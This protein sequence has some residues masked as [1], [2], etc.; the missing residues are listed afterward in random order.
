MVSIDWVTFLLK[1]ILVPIFIGVVSLAGRRWGTTVS[2]WLVG[3]PLSSAPVA[4]FL[5]L[6]QGNVFA[7]QAAEGILLGIVSVYAFCVAYSWPAMHLG[8]FRSLLAG[9]AAFFLSTFLL[10]AM[11]LPLI[12]EV[13]VSL[14]TL[15]VSLLLLP[16]VGSDKAPS[17][18]T[19]WEVPARMVSATVLV[20]LI[21]GVAN[22]LGPQL[23][24]LL[25][26]FPI[27]AAT[28][29][30]YTHRSLGGEE[31]VKL[32][33]GVIVGTSTFIVFFLIVTLTIVRWGLAASFLTA[34]G[35][36][37]LTHF[38]SLQ[39]LRFLGRVSKLS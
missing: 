32:L 36:G 19:R 22:L 20:F 31:A 33:R 30:V 34:I 5:A 16:R 7:Q 13:A 28:L 1:L 37:L 25:T 27:Y 39:L 21:T 2:G 35:A 9:M 29:G 23:T 38:T 18:R 15:V 6:E 24:G 11:T 10:N 8:W 14:L 3:L 12:V 17:W 26:P 4:F